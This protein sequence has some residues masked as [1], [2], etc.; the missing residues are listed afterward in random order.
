MMAAEQMVERLRQSEQYG[1]L[2][3]ELDQKAFYQALEKRARY[4][5]NG[6]FAPEIAMYFANPQRILGSFFI[7]HHSFRVRIDDVEHYL[8]G[9]VAYLK[10]LKKKRE[11]SDLLKSSRSSRKLE[12]TEA[13]RE[14]ASLIW[15]GDVNLGRRQHYRTEKLGIKKTINVPALAR[16]E[17]HTSELQSRGHLV[18][19]LLLEKKK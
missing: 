7:R 8:S 13:L 6:Y 16:S 10:Y 15:A 11:N 14:H 19:R 12:H 5:L 18:C 4:L 17:E 2:L 3:D 1:H 9:Y